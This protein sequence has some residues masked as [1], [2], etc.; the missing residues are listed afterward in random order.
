MC[1]LHS[2]APLSWVGVVMVRKTRS[3]SGPSAPALA[4]APQLSQ[5]PARR[6]VAPGVYDP[7][8]RSRVYGSL[9]PEPASAPRCAPSHRPG[10][11][12]CASSA[13]RGKLGVTW[14][15]T[16]TIIGRGPRRS[17]EQDSWSRVPWCDSGV[18]TPQKP[19]RNGLAAP[20]ASHLPA[21][22]PRC[23]TRLYPCASRL[24]LHRASR[25]P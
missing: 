24:R 14:G 12:L 22:L 9:I 19:M 21:C 2:D 5:D 16:F 13:C 8:R 17:L 23:Y 6:S 10:R 11:C 3:R 15:S 7:G 18:W 20:S 4:A 25:A 1:S